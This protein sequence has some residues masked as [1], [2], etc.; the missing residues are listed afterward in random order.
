MPRQC[1]VK[2]AV[3]SI[4]VN[5]QRTQSDPGHLVVVLTVAGTR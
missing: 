1:E 2:I 3:N 4:V 5:F